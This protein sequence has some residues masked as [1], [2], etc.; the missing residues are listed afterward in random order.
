MA[1]RNNLHALDTLVHVDGALDGVCI[2][3]GASC[4]L[5]ST[6]GPEGGKME[7]R[8]R[9]EVWVCE[10][11]SKSRRWCGCIIA[12]AEHKS[13][14]GATRS[15][16]RCCRTATEL[17]YKKNRRELYFF[18]TKKRMRAKREEIVKHRQKYMAYWCRCSI[19][20]SAQVYTMLVY[21]A[22]ETLL[23]KVL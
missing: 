6:L 10:W 18:Q 8:D 21:H 20:A 3:G 16:K 23:V 9:V 1:V 7:K 2:L 14:L 19:F 4:L 22:W 17:F 5:F 15:T 13:H 11:R 12:E